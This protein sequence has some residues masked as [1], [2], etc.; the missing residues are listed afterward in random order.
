MPTRRRLI[1]VGAILALT[2]VATP[3]LASGM[4]GAGIASA[5]CSRAEAQAA[6]RAHPKLDPVGIRK[7][8]FPSQVL[9][10]AFLGAGSKTM[11]VGFA[12]SVCVGSGDTV[13]GWEVYRLESGKW[14][15]AWK[16]WALSTGIVAVGTSIK[17][18]APVA[19]PGDACVHPSGGTRSRTWHWNGKR[20]ERVLGRSTPRRPP[21]SPTQRASRCGSR[22]GSSCAT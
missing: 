16:S 19:L 21:L 15:P 2:F 1:A 17:E 5:K 8:E 7:L 13:L 12:A 6:L 11:V 22:Q 14:Q 4:S 10:G 18:T 3:A 9:C 20:F